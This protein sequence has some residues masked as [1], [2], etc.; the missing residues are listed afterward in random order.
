DR[1]PALRTAAA[2]GAVEEGGPLGGEQEREVARGEPLAEGDARPLIAAVDDLEDDAVDG[3]GR[4]VG[5]EELVF[6]RAELPSGRVA[7]DAAGRLAHLWVGEVDRRGEE[8]GDL[9]GRGGHPAAALGVPRPG[10]ER[11]GLI[12][13]AVP[14]RVAEEPARFQVL[15]AARAVP[16]TLVLAIEEVA[17]GIDADAAR[18]TDPAAE[19]D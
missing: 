10:T 8:L 15:Q 7:G 2:V 11:R 12:I 9:L 13:P 17:G 14:R 5:D 3:A 6:E 1:R 16:G 19:R 18:R 4:V